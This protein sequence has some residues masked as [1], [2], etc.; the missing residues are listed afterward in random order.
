MNCPTTKKI[1]PL[2][3]HSVYSLLDGVS[4]ISEYID[5]CKESEIGACSCTDHGYVMGLYDLITKSAKSG[6]KGIPGLEAYLHPGEDYVVSGGQKKRPN[7][8]HLTLWAMNQKGY[9]NLLELSNCSW[10]DGR[11]INIFGM[12]PRITWEDLEQ[13]N[14]GIICG[15]GCILGP[16]VFPYLR[17]EKAMANLNANRL[18]DIFGNERLFMEVMPHRVDKDWKV[19]DVIQVDAMHSNITYTFDKSDMIETSAGIMSAEQAMKLK[20]PEVYSSITKRP[21]KHAFT[22]REITL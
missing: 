7:Y 17:G 2:H 3:A 5:Y 11:V 13:N 1:Y 4:T 15:S 16:I 18:I 19:K 22:E 9:S 20:V 21:Q 12:K 10:Q 6:I 8:F 14:E